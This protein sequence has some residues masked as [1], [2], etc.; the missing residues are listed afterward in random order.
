M[1][2]FGHSPLINRHSSDLFL[3][4][5]R[6]RIEGL[7]GAT[8]QPLNSGTGA[9]PPYALCT[10]VFI[11]DNYAKSGIVNT[12]DSNA[13]RSGR[14]RRT[15]RIDNRRNCPARCQRQDRDNTTACKV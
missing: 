2:S 4:H 14:R 8:I 13:C 7:G 11:I 6:N 9:R 1:N 12:G 15:F 10:R 5:D 3:H